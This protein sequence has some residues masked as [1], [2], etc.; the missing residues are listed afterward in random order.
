MDLHPAPFNSHQKQNPS[1]VFFSLSA[2]TAE[3]LIG[4][5]GKPNYELSF[6]LNSKTEKPEQDLRS[7]PS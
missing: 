3:F 6:A 1:R 2:P 5:C 7:S 4:I